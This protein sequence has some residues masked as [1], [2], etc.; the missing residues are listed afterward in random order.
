MRG[1]LDAA[2]RPILT[3]EANVERIT[4][5]LSRAVS[6]LAAASALLSDRPDKKV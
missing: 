6:T 5:N 3:I 4:G 2:L 1:E